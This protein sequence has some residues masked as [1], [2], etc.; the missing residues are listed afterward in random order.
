MR[1]IE[2]VVIDNNTG[3]EPNCELI[4][5]TE[6][7]ANNLMPY[8]ID[9]FAMTED[10]RVVLIDDCGNCAFAPSDRFTVKSDPESLRPKGRWEWCKDHW[11]CTNCRMGRYHDLVLGLDAAFCGRC[12]AKM[13][14]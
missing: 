7:W 3:R 2:F 13:E 9:S 12:G 14:G 6:D 4:A 8:D 1:L 10:G 11:E 5:K